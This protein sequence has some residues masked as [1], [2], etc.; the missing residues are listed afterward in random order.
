MAEASK[1]MGRV[2]GGVDMK[3]LFGIYDYLGLPADVIMLLINFCGRQY[4]ERYGTQRRP[5]ARAIEKEAYIWVNREIMTVEQAEEY[6]RAADERRGTIAEVKN[7]IGIRGRELTKTEQGYVSSWLD[8]GYGADVIAVAYDRTVTNTGALK[9]NYM[10]KI[11]LS[12]HEK[13]VRTARDIDEGRP[14][15]KPRREETPPRRAAAARRT[16]RG[17]IPC[18]TRYERGGL[19]WATTGSFWHVPEASLKTYAK[20]THPSMSAARRWYMPACRRSHR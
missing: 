3:T 8:M 1:V 20:R 9:W 5:S 11:L 12:W 16:L 18:W 2:L 19:K 17:W 6:I 4:A 7:A 10:N 13:G 14:A 15:E